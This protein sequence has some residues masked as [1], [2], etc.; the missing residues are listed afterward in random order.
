M[1]SVSWGIV[2]IHANNRAVDWEHKAS[3]A[4]IPSF[5]ALRT[6]IHFLFDDVQLHHFTKFSPAGASSQLWCALW[7]HIRGG[8]Q[9][10]RWAICDLDDARVTASW[11]LRRQHECWWWND[12][13]LDLM[14]DAPEELTLLTHHLMQ[15]IMLCIVWL[16][17]SLLPFYIVCYSTILA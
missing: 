2:A 17:W 12:L 1:H 14:R 8:N 9:L 7:S 4:P 16:D 6:T 3:L 11:F 10:T 13:D 15:Y 5:R